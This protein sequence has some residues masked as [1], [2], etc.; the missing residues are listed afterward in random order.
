M[1]VDLYFSNQLMPLADKLHDH[2]RPGDTDVNV[3]EP[4]VVIVPNMNLSKWIKLTLARKASIFMN[5][6]FRYLEIGL[7]KMI[8]SLDPDPIEPERLTSNNAAVLLFFILMSLEGDVPDLIPVMRYLGRPGGGR[9]SDY[10]IRCWQLSGELARLFQE[11]E[12]H[13]S[14]MIQRWLAD[15]PAEDAMESCQKWIFRKMVSLKDRLGRSTGRPL[16]ALPE[17]ARMV[18]DPG[19][20]V[21]RHGGTGLA[22]VHLFGLSQTSPFHLELLSRLKSYYDIHIYSLNPSREYWEDI[23]TPFEKKWIDRKKVG[24]LKLGREEWAA[25][26]LFSDV[27]HA[28]LS[29]WGRPGRESVRMLCQLTDYDFQA[30]FSEIPQ[31]DTVLAAI[32]SSL[33]TLDEGQDDQAALVQDASLQIM[34]CPGIR[35]EVETVYDSICT[36]LEMD[37]ALCMTDIAVMVSDMTRYKPV[38]DSVFNRQPRRITFNLVDSHAR[39][40]SIFA[41]AV[42]SLVALARGDFSRGRVFDLLRNPCVMHRWAY[43]S[44]AV[45]VWVGW[46]DALGIFHGYENKAVPGQDLPPGGPFSWRQGLTR[47]RMSRIMSQPGQPA[48]W[49]AFH[50]DGVVPYGDIHTGDDRLMEKFCRLVETLHLALGAL[51]MRSATARAWRD[52]FF[53]VVDQFIGISHEMRGEEAVFQSL[54]EAFEDFVRYDALAGLEPGSPLTAEALWTFVKTHLEG[55]SG[56]QGDYLTGGVTVSAMMPMRPIPF[57]IVYVLGLEEGRFPG[58]A[59]PSLLDLRIR[60]RCIGDISV[61]ERNRYLFLEIL[62]S[63]RR[64]LYLS[65]VSRDLQKDREQAPCSVVHQLRHYV[66]GQVLGGQPFRVIQIPIKEDGPACSA[67]WGVNDGCGRLPQTNV[68]RRLS[69]YRRSG[70][71]PEFMRRASAVD[72]DKA[73]RYDPDWSLPDRPP[74]IDPSEPVDL[75]IGLLRRFLIDP[76]E[77]VGRYHLGLAESVDPGVQLDEVNHEPLSS[78]FPI[79]YVIRTVPIQNWLSAQLHGSDRQASISGLEDEFE[80]VYADL[81]RRSR[82]PVGAFG[83]EDRYRLKRQVRSVGDILLPFVEQMRSAGQFFSAVRVG[84]SSDDWMTIDGAQLIFDPVS[85]DLPET[86]DAYLPRTVRLDGGIPWVW[87]A[88][89]HAW[90]CLVVTGSNRKTRHPDKYVIKSLLTLMALSAGGQAVPWSDCSRM[91]LHIVYREHVINLDYSLEPTRCAS[92]LSGLLKDFFTPFPLVWLPFETIFYR[93]DLRTAIG[94]EDGGDAQRRM[95]RAS[96]DETFRATADVWADLT[97]AMVT[98]DILERARRRFSVF[99]P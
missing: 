20:T 84:T 33:L 67:F 39:T 58:H 48:G 69:C 34:A 55:I 60:K 4:S 74:D 93:A 42:L 28:L 24:T 30:G 73:G 2:L 44:D 5:V 8:R 29:A 11:Y 80:R 50:F 35:R 53:R 7:W 98:P 19:R 97:G 99:L 63:V 41:Q 56:G 62:I 38:V 78:I 88:K 31:P 54:V 43:G 46:A 27:D 86:A 47:L 18:L 23:K 6:E 66:E 13:R 81:S 15:R 94:R 79:D 77:V 65:Y 68:A 22:P 75:S 25:G 37:P 89:D 26:E 90:H 64:R 32:A 85:I 59:R 76:V 16:A 91:N 3:L 71:W 21:N 10:E 92:Y 87:Q 61:A 52:V 45:A 49:P 82:V 70:L 12:Y 40:E 9:R 95:F 83:A 36:N 57:K 17:Y 1:G 72:L 96:M 14:E 51:K